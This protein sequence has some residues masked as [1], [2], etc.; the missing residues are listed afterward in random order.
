[1]SVLFKSNSKNF[2]WVGLTPTR[3]FRCFEVF[4]LFNVK[5]LLI[6]FNYNFSFIFCEPNMTYISYS[7]Q[8]KHCRLHC[9][10]PQQLVFKSIF[11]CIFLEWPFSGT[12]FGFS[13]RPDNKGV[14]FQVWTGGFY[15]RSAHA[16]WTI[17]DQFCWEWGAEKSKLKLQFYVINWVIKKADR[18]WDSNSFCNSIIHVYE[19]EHLIYLIFLKPYSYTSQKN[20][21]PK[22]ICQKNIS[23]NII[24]P[25]LT[26]VRNDTC[27]NEHFPEITSARMNTCLKLHLP[28]WTLVWNYI[29]QNEHL[30][31]CTLA[32]NEHLSEITFPRKL[33]CQNLHLPECTFGRNCIF[34]KTCLP[35]FTLARMYIWPKL[36]FH[37]KLICQNLPLPECTFGRNCISPK[38]HFPDII[39][40]K[41]WNF[42]IHIKTENIHIK[43]IF[44]FY[45]FCTHKTHKN[46]KDIIHIKTEISLL[47]EFTL[48]KYIIMFVH[49]QKLLSSA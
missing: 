34:P 35:E 26:F 1:M 2:I 44:G 49:F 36:H 7:E 15:Q 22:I 43:H 21:S 4:W 48:R 8:A 11:W 6:L 5:L 17:P 45:V 33:I 38:I 31:E 25:E 46:R 18:R 42:V 19:S 20:I 37:R 3:F 14:R 23:L 9:W 12:R 41:T 47:I 24:F 40:I 10:E 32:R 16:G 27:Q 28:K 30:P 13:G 29:C 39:H